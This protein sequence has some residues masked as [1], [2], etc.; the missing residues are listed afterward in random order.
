MKVSNAINILYNILK[1]IFLLT[2]FFISNNL[3]YITYNIMQK[4]A[5]KKLQIE[6]TQIYLIYLI[7]KNDIDDDILIRRT[8]DINDAGI[9]NGFNKD[10]NDDGN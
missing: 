9:N 2:N 4:F 8:I 5:E 1:R 3:K 7:I 10:D 6:I